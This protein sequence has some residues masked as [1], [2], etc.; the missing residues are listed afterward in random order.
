V[1]AASVLRETMKQGITVLLLL[2]LKKESGRIMDM[3]VGCRRPTRG[4]PSLF[5][6]RPTMKLARRIHVQ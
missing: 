3:D 5:A 1:N 2:W 4:K 6:L